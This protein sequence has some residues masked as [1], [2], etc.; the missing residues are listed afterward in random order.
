V[1]L[2]EILNA[3]A[4]FGL[5]NWDVNHHYLIFELLPSFHGLH[6]ADSSLCQIRPFTASSNYSTNTHYARTGADIVGD[7]LDE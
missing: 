5:P 2:L 7:I 6:H 3:T 1:V 4:F